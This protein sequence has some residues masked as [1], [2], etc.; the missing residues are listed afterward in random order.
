MASLSNAD[1]A[2]EVTK[3]LVEIL[4]DVELAK[5][6]INCSFRVGD[7]F[8]SISNLSKVDGPEP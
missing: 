2:Q 1:V 8:T 3:K 6:D 5:V 7:T 4:K